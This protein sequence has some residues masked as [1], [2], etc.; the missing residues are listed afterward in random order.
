ML[1]SNRVIG[2]SL[3]A[4]SLAV[5]PLALRSA[6]ADAPTTQAADNTTTSADGL[7][8]TLIKPADDAA[9]VGD[10]V[11]V[12]YVGKL[13]DGTEFDNSYSRGEPIQ[14]TLGQGQVIKGWE[15]GLLGLK[16]GEKR[17]LTIP[18]EL[19]YGPEGRPP[20]IPQNATLIFDVELMGLKRG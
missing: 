12:H 14:L 16:V 5:C 18:P 19:A 8:S 6:H 15:E 13:Q 7:K 11:W 2:L 3:L 10:T 20:K 9:K 17:E 1:K 4:A